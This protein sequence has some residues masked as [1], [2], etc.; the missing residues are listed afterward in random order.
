MTGTCWCFSTTSELESEEI[1][2]EK[3]EINLS[4]MFTVR[5]I[6]IEKA[7]N[8]I[9][10]QG[11]AQFG[12]GGLGHDAI[13]AVAT[14][15]AIPLEDYTGLLNGQKIYNHEKMF[16]QLKKYLDSVLKK[17]PISND[18]LTG[19]TKILDNN[20]GIPPWEFTYEGK[21]YTPKSFA[22]DVLEVSMQ[23]II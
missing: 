16:G 14:Y 23:M 11:K 7:K 15:G 9:L 5:N 2:K 12:E 10:R 13:R 6:Y 1:R 19:Y 21:N 22:K 18:W 8:Y 4:E 3:K 20:L 17:Q